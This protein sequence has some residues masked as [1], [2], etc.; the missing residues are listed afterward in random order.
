MK[1][2]LYDTGVGL[3]PFLK[4]IIKKEKYN[5]YYLYMDEDVFPI[6]KKDEVFIINHLK[7]ILNYASKRF[8][9]IVIAC[10]TISSYLKC[11]DTGKY[12]IEILSIFEDNI[13][14]L[15]N[16]T[17]FL[18]T[19][20]TLR[21]VKHQYVIDGS[22]LPSLIENNQIKEIIEFINNLDFKT[23]KIILGCTHF[24][25]IKFIFEDFHKNKTFIS[26]EDELVEKIPNSGF[27]S[28]DGNKKAKKYL[29]TYLNFCNK[30]L[31]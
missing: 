1:V 22:I 8:D 11:I 28:I 18:A 12:N 27:I 13:K 10:N 5:E 31:C 20:G 6:G 25:L 19:K 17:T 21:N 30:I 2:M 9:Q 14:L 3:L 7:F 23:E 24:P 29:A 16:N 4:S 15:D 26:G